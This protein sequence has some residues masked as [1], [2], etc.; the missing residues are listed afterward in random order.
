MSAMTKSID[1]PDFGP[2]EQPAKADAS[3]F[4]ARIQRVQTAMSEKGLTHLLVYGDREHFANL[5]WL[6]N[7][8]PRF[9]EAMLI[10]RVEGDPLLLV[11]NECEAYLPHSPLFAA[12]KLRGE[13]YRPFSLVSQIR[14]GSRQMPDILESEGIEPGG[15]VGCAGWKYF[16]AIEE[17]NAEQVIEIPA[18]IV[19]AA[20]A[21]AGADNVVNA[22]DLFV[23]PGYGLRATVTAREIAEFEYWNMK[24]SHAV[25]RMISGLKPG[26]V[27]YQMAAL[28]RYD[29]TPLN[30]HMTLASGNMPGLSSPIGRNLERGQPM[31]L[32]FAYW[33]SNTCRAGWIAQSEADLPA[34]AA[35]YSDAFAFPYFEAMAEWL[36]ALQV[37][38]AG[39][40]LHHI[41]Y[42][43]LPFDQ[44]GIF[45]NAGHLA[46]LDE[47]VSS[48]IYEGSDLK[49]RS[50][51]VM[52][53][54]VIPASP[55]YG[56]TR[57]E[58]GVVIADAKLR[59]ELE[60]AW[61]NCFARC[62]ARRDFMQKTLGLEVPED[63]LPL[64]DIAG[65]VPPWFL[66][67]DTVIA[68]R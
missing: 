63:V 44:F 26:M 45:L 23:H 10:I 13:T 37:G 66:A 39:S 48:P 43:Q 53:V 49:I 56:S 9:E 32:N 46:H 11:G 15:K 17:A 25:S 64:S 61:P 68:L 1:W 35:D 67:P 50:G 27:D 51:M 8:D 40:A 29:G 6:T 7:I 34:P 14:T 55:V 38:A 21:L 65:I 57:M 42:D 30:C 54:D 16:T 62:Q 58:D 59:R 4:E 12:G 36:A 60:I 24:A 22:S 52:Q 33:G 5:A 47:W 41:V 20:R 19:D 3:V 18:F 2:A 28:G 31:S